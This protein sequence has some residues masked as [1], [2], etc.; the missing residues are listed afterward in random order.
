MRI[1]AIETT[2]RIGSVAALDGAELVAEARLPSDQ[3][4]AQSLA[5]ALAKLLKQLGWLAGDV[6]LIA[7]TDGPG[8]FT[9]LRI[10]VTTAKTLAYA[11]GADV[12]GVNT[13]EVIAAQAPSLDDEVNAKI[14][15]VIDAQ[16]EQLCSASFSWSDR[17]AIHCA[18]ETHIVDRADWLSSRQPGEVVTGPGLSRLTD[19]LPQHVTVVDAEHWAPRAATVGKLA[20]AHYESGRRDDLFQL[21]PSYYRPSA[22]EEK[23]I[24]RHGGDAS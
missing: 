17:A 16:R 7:V 4:S 9:G 6:D 21:V 19:D 2:E 10:G 24:E 1:L 15:A 13:L 22:A 23:W 5:P 14:T 12:L 8:S 11:A 18:G 3:R 20:V